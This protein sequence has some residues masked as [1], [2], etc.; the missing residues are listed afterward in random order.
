MSTLQNRICAAAALALLTIS[1]VTWAADGPVNT[2]PKETAK[3]DDLAP[4]PAAKSI[5]QSA[6][7]AGKRVDYQVTVGAIALKDDKGKLL[8]EVV[9]TAYTVPGSGAVRPVTFAFNGGPG[10]ASAYLNLGAIGP[11]KINMGLEDDNP[12]DQ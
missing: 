12:S 9:Y 6:V 5:R 11:K 7:V 4:F 10:A 3:F 1:G 8:G 2:P